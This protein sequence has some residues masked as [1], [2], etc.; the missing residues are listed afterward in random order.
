MKEVNYFYSRTRP[1]LGRFLVYF[2]EL[3]VIIDGKNDIYDQ[4]AINE[5]L[6]KKIK[7]IP[8]VTSHT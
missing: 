6:K 8:E 5:L 3:W 2:A 7:K 1:L 4:N